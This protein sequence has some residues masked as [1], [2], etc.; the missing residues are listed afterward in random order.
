MSIFATKFRNY[1]QIRLCLFLV[2]IVAE[3]SQRIG[4]GGY[5]IS[6]AIAYVP[7]VFPVINAPSVPGDG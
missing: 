7:R 6:V 4:L 2:C 3:S 5:V 1:K